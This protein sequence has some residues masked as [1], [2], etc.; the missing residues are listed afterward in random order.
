[1]TLADRLKKPLVGSA[2]VRTLRATVR[3]KAMRALM[4]LSARGPLGGQ[5]QRCS[6]HARTIE[7][8]GSNAVYS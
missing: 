8:C 1:M 2:L 3:Q 4:K 6:S 5:G 7:V